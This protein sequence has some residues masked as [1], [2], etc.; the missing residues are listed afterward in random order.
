MDDPRAD[1]EGYV[2][3][4]YG[5]HFDSTF[6]NN[7]EIMMAAPVGPYY[8]GNVLAPGAE[9]SL[10]FRLS[11]PEPCNGDFTDGQIYFWGEAI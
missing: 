2:P 9:M 10:T 1:A 5:D 11:L 7:N 3:I 8:L 6:Y 4:G